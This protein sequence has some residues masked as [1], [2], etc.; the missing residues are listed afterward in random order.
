MIK[1]LQKK[2]I[3]VAMC[4]TLAVLTV[5]VALMIGMNY[6][7]M[8]QRADG[9]LQMLAEHD[10]TFPERFGE[11]GPRERQ[12]EAASLEE[13]QKNREFPEEFL[14]PEIPYET[15]YFSVHLDATGAYLDSDTRNIAAVDEQ[16]AENFAAWVW[17]SGKNKG[18]LDTY[19]YLKTSKEEGWLLVFLD[20][21]QDYAFV[22]VF[23]RNSILASVVGLIAVF[24]LVL[25]FSRLV[26]R[27]VAVSYEKQKRFI[28]DASHELK[29]PLTII[30]ANTEVLEMENGTSPWLDSIRKQTRRLASLTEQMVMLS[31]LDEGKS[32]GKMEDFSLSH[33]VQEAAE[34]FLIVEK[35]GEKKIFLDIEPGIVFHGEEGAIRQMVT[36]LLDNA[37][38]Y[39]PPGGQI[40]IG[41]HKKGKKAVLT[42][43]NTV[44]KIETGTQEQLFERFYRR[45]TSRNSRTGGSGIGLSIVK[46]IVIAHRGKI[47]AES[48]DGKSIEFRIVLS[49]ES[50]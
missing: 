39:S 41:L 46:G 3:L 36:L 31:R 15:R 49:V 12:D 43:Y 7:K 37:V 11:R 5:V 16:V 17:K 6:M 27:P 40:C 13:R 20:C 33:S 26:F 45:D 29:T 28:T 1:S 32:S 48:K 19:R 10:G 24:T 35:T 8:T 50:I 30:D 34:P 47:T 18:F 38:K 23:V 21:Q 9:M 22:R 14:S 4:S 25:F 2:F 42:V 44:E